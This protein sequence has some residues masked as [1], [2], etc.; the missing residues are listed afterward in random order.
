MSNTWIEA[1][2][3]LKKTFE[4]KDFKE[5]LA[6]VNRVGETAERLGHH[7]DICIKNYNNV[8]ISTTTHDKGNI[9]TAKDR[10]LARAI[11]DLIAS[12][13]HASSA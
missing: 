10:E 1:D 6:F 9:V 3:T 4:W 5:A 12:L 13:P 2:D 11:D 7:P 8:F